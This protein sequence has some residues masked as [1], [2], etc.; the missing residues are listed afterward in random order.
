MSHCQEMLWLMLRD[1]LAV[2]ILR[3]ARLLL[4]EEGRIGAAPRRGA[5]RSG[6]RGSGLHHILPGTVANREGQGLPRVDGGSHG[7]LWED[8][9]WESG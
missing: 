4:S 7:F 6:L 9:E 5:G 1:G 3:G 2:D 8:G